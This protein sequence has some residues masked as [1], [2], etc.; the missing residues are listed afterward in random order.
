L[1]VLL[2]LLPRIALGGMLQRLPVLLHA[3][4]GVEYC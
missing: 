1:C 4:A 2:L 3:A